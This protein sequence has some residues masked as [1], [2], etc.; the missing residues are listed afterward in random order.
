MKNLL[1]SVQECI[2]EYED[3][4]EEDYVISARF[5]YPKT[6]IVNADT[7]RQ[8]PPGT[9]LLSIMSHEDSENVGTLSIEPEQL[10]TYL[11]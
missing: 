5:V 3:I 9:I 4:S 7:G 10:N 1:E 2:N 11:C 8:Y 6:P